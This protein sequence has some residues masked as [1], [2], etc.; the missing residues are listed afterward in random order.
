[1]HCFSFPLGTEPAF[2]G[3]DHQRERRRAADFPS[4]F[5]LPLSR[6]LFSSE[7]FQSYSSPEVFAGIWGMRT[8]NG[9]SDDR[10]RR[11]GGNFSLIHRTL[12]SM[13]SVSNTLYLANA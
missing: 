12:N 10:E 13:A 8:L 3:R 2:R 4:L 6:P 5:F 11:Q 9:D 7:L 1:M